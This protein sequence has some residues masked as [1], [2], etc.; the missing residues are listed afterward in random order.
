MPQLRELDYDDTA[1]AMGGN[2]NR[3]ADD[4]RLLVRIFNH[5]KLNQTETAEQGRQIWHEVPYIQI[6]QPG[7][8]D[9]I[10]I[11]PMTEMDKQ[12]FIEHFRKF[13]ARESQEGIDG[14]LLEEIPWISRSQV[15]ELKFMNVRTIEQLLDVSDVNAQNMPMGFS[16]L[17]QKAERY[18]VHAQEE[19]VAEQLESKLSERDN[20]IEAL[21]ARVEMLEKLVPEE[22]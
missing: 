3:Y 7:N 4:N 8:K 22:E 14:T 20:Q 12:R 10:V 17:K 6:M 2:A 9:S 15:E 21:M 1:M 5:P 18:L 16:M 19:G 11:R 13:E